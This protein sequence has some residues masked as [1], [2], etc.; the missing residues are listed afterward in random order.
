MA[1]R[2]TDILVRIFPFDD[3]K[4]YYPVE[5]ELGDGSRFDDG[6]FVLDREKLLR[7]ELDADAYG[8][9]LFE[10]LFSGDI[11]RAYERAVGIADSETEDR[12]RV[13]LWID[14]EAVELHAIPW[15]RMYHLHRGQAVPLSAST[16]TPFSRYTSLEASE[17][18]PVKDFP[19]KMLIAASNPKNL[20]E[21]MAA[22]DV[23]GE[24]EALYQ[25]VREL[26]KSKKLQVSI[27]PG[28]TGLPGEL[29]AKLEADKFTVL[30]GPTNLF[31]I[32]PHLADADIFHF[33]GHGMF[34]RESERGDGKAA[35]YLE[36]ADGSWQ[37]VWDDDIVSMFT[38]LG[39][40]P[41]CVFL[42]ACESARR[43]EDGQSPFVGLGPKLV[44]A[45][46]PAVVAMQDKVPMEL[47]RLFA[48]EFYERLTEHGIVD[49]ALNQARL[50]V[51]DDEHT[52]WAIPVLFMRI[53]K[54]RLFGEDED[55][56]QAGPPVV[57]WWPVAASL[58]VIAMLLGAILWFIVPRTPKEMPPGYFNV[59]V[60]EFIVQDAAG[61]PINSRDGRYL[62]DYLSERVSTQFR[63][64][65]LGNDT[66]Y[67]VWNSKQTGKISGGTPDEREAAAKALAD[68]INASIVIYGVITDA[69]E[70]SNFTLEFFVNHEAFEDIS[71]VEGKH[72]MGR[73]VRLDL[74]FSKAVQAIDNPSL[75]GR[76]R[77]LNLLTL[78]LAYYSLDDYER[79]LTYF[80]QA[81]SE[82]RWVGRGKEVAYMLI[83][84]SYARQASKAQ[85]FSMLPLAMEN[86]QK[87]L[88][89][90]GSYGRALIGEASV[91][92]LESSD[93]VLGQCDI[94]GLGQ[95]GELLDQ[96]LALEDQP[97]SASIE[98]KVHYYDG[99]IANLMGDKCDQANAE[100][101]IKIAKDEFNW[102]VNEYEH[103]KQAGQDFAIIEKFASHAYSE[104][105]LIA[106][107]HDQEPDLAI[108]YLEKAVESASPYYK[109][110]NSYLIG[111]IY[112]NTNRPDQARQAYQQAITIA[113]TYA[114]GTSLAKYQ[115]ALDGLEGQ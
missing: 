35:L 10:S 111:L 99:H 82:T 22:V 61:N 67:E 80:E 69:G 55:E 94:E 27:M 87:A 106:Y 11:L 29:Q 48:G 47:A 12:L 33:I 26:V 91:S 13:R 21:G 4:N 104:L 58:G 15:E 30:E 62:A 6:R 107:R 96:A 85:D 84:N 108:S 57:K 97:A 78:G 24:I 92:Y 28:L 68:R 51:Y 37:G 38:A 42:T 110:Y 86:Y 44:Q 17:P 31:T 63:E 7:S 70:Q 98:T 59:A 72:E 79:A 88:E 5:A 81:A 90:N 49:K 41:H 14:E 46:I 73:P 102:V 19:L 100:K 40:L 18:E 76:T 1:E 66:A 95:A 83:G 32:A 77:A 52:S 64:I 2:Y 9:A 8:M 89:I 3:A 65:N 113:D 20:P 103:R 75:A 34:K 50:Q 25:S 23:A 112:Q 43:A 93:K 45:G 115:A 71:E 53:R 56:V 54:G 114:D 109:G 74:P 101:W 16:L 60:A 36:K 39:T 105:G